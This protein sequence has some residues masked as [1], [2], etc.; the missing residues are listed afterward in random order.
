MG[1]MLDSSVLIEAE[2]GRL[3]LVDRLGRVGGETVAIAAITASELLHG[4]HRAR[5]RQDR[6]RRERFVEWIL[7]E[8][9]VAEFGLGVAR[10][11][12]EL[13]AGLS[14]RGETVGAHDLL[15]AATAL[16]MDLR[17]VTGNVRE[18]RRIPRLQVESW[19]ES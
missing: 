6:S 9:P 14:E 7:R 18:F 5:T 1:L 19:L 17:L 11:H 10:T 13:W 3:D 2:R 16:T 12:A 15:I 4:V 8:L